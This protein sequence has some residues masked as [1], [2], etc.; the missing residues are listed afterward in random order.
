MPDTEQRILK[1]QVT[2]GEWLDIR[3][4]CVR[5]VETKRDGPYSHIPYLEVR[6]HGPGGTDDELLAEFCRHQIVGVYY[7][8]FR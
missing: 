8:D 3:S 6:G 5:I 1:I 4:D 2:P 7:K